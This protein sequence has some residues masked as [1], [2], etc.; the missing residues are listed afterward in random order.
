M[1]DE[2]PITAAVETPAKAES[3][4]AEQVW[5]WLTAL[6]A[7]LATLHDS[8]RLHAAVRLE[9]IT[10]DDAGQPQLVPPA[11]TTEWNPGDGH[12][13]YPPEM[14]GKTVG[15]LST[16]LAA[17]HQRLVQAGI[18]IDPRRID[19][20][21]LGA[22]LCR[23]TGQTGVDAYL[24]SAKA[25]AKVSKRLRPIIDRCLGFDPND[26]FTDCRQVCVAVRQADEASRA[27]EADTPALGIIE[28]SSLHT[29]PTGHR[30]ATGRPRDAT[31]PVPAFARLGGYRILERIG[32]GG[33]GDVFKAIDEGLQRVVAIKVLPA[34]LARHPDFVRRFRAEATAIARLVHPN[35]VQVFAC[36]EDAGHHY[37]VMQFVPGESLA[38]LLARR[39]KLAIDETLPIIAQCLAG[40]AAA[41]AQGLIH[42]DIKPGNIL[43]DHEH[44]RA[45][46]AD[47]GLVKTSGSGENLTAT[48]VIMGTVDYIP[49]EQARGLKVDS[50]S[51]LYSVGALMYRMLSGRLPFESDSPT[52][53][54]FQHAFEQPRPLRNVSPEVPEALAAIVMRLLEKY[55]DNRYQSAEELNAAIA[56]FRAGKPLAQPALRPAV[57][58]RPEPQPPIP[59]NPDVWTP[60]VAGRRGWHTRLWTLFHAHA[61]AAVKELLDTQHQLDAAVLEYQ[62]RRDQLAQLAQQAQQVA[63]DFNVQVRQHRQAA[64][65]AAQRVA[66]T[67]DAESAAEAQQEQAELQR[68]ADEF[69]AQLADQQEQLHD[70]RLQLAQV[71]ATL[72]KL[73]SQRDVLQAR[74]KTAQAEMDMRHEA[75]GSRRSRP[76][77]PVLFAVAMIV[78]F[79]VV[80]SYMFLQHQSR[81]V[82]VAEF[83]RSR[84]LAKLPSAQPVS[85]PLATAPTAADGPSLVGR[86]TSKGKDTSLVV[87]YRAGR[88]LTSAPIRHFISQHDLAVENVEIALHGT[89]HVPDDGQ[90]GPPRKFNVAVTQ[91][92]GS[93]LDGSTMH[94][95]VDSDQTVTWSTGAPALGPGPHRLFIDGEKVGPDDD[96]AR[97]MFMYPLTLAP[98][99]HQVTWVLRGWEFED[100]NELEFFD[101]A[102]L[103]SLELESQPLPVA[104]KE[105]GH[106]VVVDNVAGD[107]QRVYQ[108][109]DGWP[110]Q[111]PARG[112]TPPT[113]NGAS[114]LGRVIYE[115]KDIGLAIRY[116]AGRPLK[117][118]LIDQFILEHGGKLQRVKLDLEGVLHVP[119][120][121]RVGVWHKGGTE[122]GGVNYLFVDSHE[123]GS[124][125]HHR[126][127]EAAYSIA[128][129]A[130]NHSVR[131]R[132]VGGVLGDENLLDFFDPE[133]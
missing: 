37:F 35:V 129:A 133:T 16:E 42:R 65:E 52:G 26:R 62:R 84:L 75:N 73:R 99:D 81:A 21:Q 118:S 123:I 83:E 1:A 11:A 29:P 125:G 124:I 91:Q 101:P 114:L 66:S 109:P 39:A 112:P 72:T 93:I 5:Q 2:R 50:R 63:A 38:G 43:L 87:R 127:K 8:G 130:G 128:L 90:A 107:R 111:R 100:D 14:Q 60:V 98:G 28:P 97:K 22:L 104:R 55:P 131:W 25:R 31:P 116:A 71:D 59:P 51:D 89:L 120:A 20:Y 110:A 119:R 85:R 102:T 48:G 67:A 23:L 7:Q 74:L 54:I 40:L 79:A 56:A 32:G 117:G 10:L 44:G 12:Q 88:T 27:A 15:T 122:N 70:L 24:R 9:N 33:M 41:H 19:A 86:A 113:A 49:P 6:A 95:T 47:F 18:V 115:D 17:A 30:P 96:G 121:M 80:L 103:R 94:M 106:D 57:S 3:L 76:W 61:P 4:T 82:R 132:L 108:T 45:L 64:A 92:R 126:T 68:V 69:A 34:E 77:R 13:Q 36:G 46:V 78:M 58:H 105:L 53:M